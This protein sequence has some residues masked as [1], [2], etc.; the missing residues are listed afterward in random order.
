M[1]DRVAGMRTG[2]GNVTQKARDIHGAKSDGSFPVFDQQSAMSALKL[3][4]HRT[5][6]AR[7]RIV[8]R[9]AGWANSNNNAKVKNAVANAREADA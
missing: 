6:E 7:Q 8:D 1:T 4:G 9:V 2:E 5:G 3:R